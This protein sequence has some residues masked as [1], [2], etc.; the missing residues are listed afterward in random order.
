[1][2]TNNWLIFYKVLTLDL[3]FN[4][5]YIDN[6]CILLHLHTE[7]CITAAILMNDGSELSL[8]QLIGSIS[9]PSK[10]T[11]NCQS[12]LL[13]FLKFNSCYWMAESFQLGEF[14]PPFTCYYFS[15]NVSLELPHNTSATIGQHVFTL[16]LQHIKCYMKS[17]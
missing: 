15:E 5:S 6:L 4:T 2:L 3:E 16:R 8:C 7:K 9:I 11:Q 12:L 13:S 1:M 17:F 10:Q 14:S